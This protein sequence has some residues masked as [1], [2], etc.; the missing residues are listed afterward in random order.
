MTE[1]GPALAGIASVVLLVPAAVVVILAGNYPQPDAAPAQVISYFRN[2]EVE[3]LISVLCEAISYGFFLWWLAGLSSLLRRDGL[4]LGSGVA[5]AVMILLQDAV[6]ATV[7]KI[8]DHPGAAPAVDALWTFAFLEAWP[9][10]RP[11]VV[12]FFAAV[13]VAL[14]RTRALP[15][16][17]TQLAFAAAIINGVFIPSL[18]VDEGPLV[19]G[20]LLPHVTATLITHVWV[21]VA[22]V[23][24]LRHAQAETACS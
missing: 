1:R 24:M 14:R 11:V 3:L 10:T 21:L 19:S 22:A 7:A 17:I 13:G 5:Y 9:F 6:L 2:H 8:V 23:A 20:G 18:F 15:P 4:V 12:A 16:P